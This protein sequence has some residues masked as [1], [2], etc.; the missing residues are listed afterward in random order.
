MAR[1]E[2]RAS[3]RKTESEGEYFGDSRSPVPQSYS[4]NKSPCCGLGVGYQARAVKDQSV[5]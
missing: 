3:G 5:S 4:P 1:E 2:P